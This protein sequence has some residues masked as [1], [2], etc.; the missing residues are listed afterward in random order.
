MTCGDHYML[1]NIK[2]LFSYFCLA[3]AL[4]ADPSIACANVPETLIVS[5]VTAH[6][7]YLQNAVQG[8]LI[9]PSGDILKTDSMGS[10][11]NRKIVIETPEE[12]SYS[13]YFQAVIAI[14]PKY[15]YVVG[16]IDAHLTSQPALIIPFTPKESRVQGFPQSKVIRIG[17]TSLPIATFQIPPS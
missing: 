9:T 5:Y 15:C 12:G 7:N 11:E 6:L 4:L 14:S 8:V 1:K 13:A 17:D 3:C 10:F 16:G 2:K